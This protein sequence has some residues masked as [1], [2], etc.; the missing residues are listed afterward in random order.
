M[1]RQSDTDPLYSQDIGKDTTRLDFA[2][3]ANGLVRE[4][5]PLCYL[6]DPK[7]DRIYFPF[8]KLHEFVGSVVEV[9]FSVRVRSPHT[10][11]RFSALSHLH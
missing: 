3:L 9:V 5:D 2:G 1:L 4:K 10:F 11:G 6:H 8:G 7:H